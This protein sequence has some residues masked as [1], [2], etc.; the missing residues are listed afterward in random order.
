MERFLLRKAKLLRS[1][2]LNLQVYR[3]VQAPD[4]NPLTAQLVMVGHFYFP[5]H[6]SRGA[7]KDHFP[8]QGTLCWVPCL[9]MPHIRGTIPKW[10]FLKMEDP[11]W[12]VFTEE[13]EQSQ[14]QGATMLRNPHMVGKPWSHP[15][16]HVQW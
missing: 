6:P 7:L 15:V 1:L 14:M 12:V 3:C 11:V 13:S 9:S 2:R 4:N 8:L 5:I 10:M 16:P